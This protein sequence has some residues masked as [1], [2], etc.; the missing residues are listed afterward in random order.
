MAYHISMQT[1]LATAQKVDNDLR[2]VSLT[3]TG[4][5]RFENWFHSSRYHHIRL[6]KIHLANRKPYCG[7][8]PGPCAIS[9]FLPRNRDGELRKLPRYRFLEWQDWLD[10]NTWINDVLDKYQVPATV[11]SL[12]SFTHRKGLQ[13]RLHYSWYNQQ[14]E[15]F[16]PHFEGYMPFET[17][18][19]IPER[20]LDGVNLAER[21]PTTTWRKC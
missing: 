13:R 10:F 19:Q 11:T 2:Q 8:H 7:N 4:R 20:C 9:P 3:D 16:T 18:C 14:Q 17:E 21:F 15:G 12:G 1:D 6:Y 5:F